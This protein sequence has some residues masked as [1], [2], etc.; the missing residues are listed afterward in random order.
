ML[1]TTF[2]KVAVAPG[3]MCQGGPLCEVLSV[4][5]AAWHLQNQLVQTRGKL[6]VP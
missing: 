2:A 4:E 6:H 1:M 3:T 5:C